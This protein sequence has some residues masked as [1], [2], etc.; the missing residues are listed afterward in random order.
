MKFYNQV[1]WHLHDITK[2][3]PEDIRLLISEKIEL[4]Y[5]GE[6]DNGKI[7]YL[8]KPVKKKNGFTL[9]GLIFE[10]SELGR[11]LMMKTF[12]ASIEHLGIHSI[13][14]DF[15]IYEEWLKGK[16]QKMAAFVINCIEDLC[17]I[18]YMKTRVNDLLKNV[19]IANAVSYATINSTNVRSTQFFLQSALLSFIIAGQ[20]KFAIP[21]KYKKD[22]L[23]I[24]TS[25]YDFEKFLIEKEMEPN[26]SW[27]FDEDVNEKKMQMATTIYDTLMKYGFSKDIVHL[28]YTDTRQLV[29]ESTVLKIEEVMNVLPNTFK[30]Q[31][32]QFS[33][34]PTLTIM[35]SSFKNA[36]NNLMH[37]LVMEYVRKYKVI[38]NYKE[39]SKN[40]QFDDIVY[41][42]QDLAEY[43]R[44]YAQYKR[45]ISKITE[46]IKFMVSDYESD[47]NKDLG[48]I[49]MQAA[50][51]A[52]ATGD[53]N[54]FARDDTPKR[55]EG[56]AI[57]L[58]TSHSLRPF[59]I[60]PRDMALCLA[61]I[62]KE[63]IDWDSWGLYTFDHKFT[64]V[65]DVKEVYGQDV[66]A[67]IGGLKQGGLSFIPD[68][69]E[70]TSRL[71]IRTRAEYN[72]LFVISD[73]LSTGYPDIEEKMI[74]TIKQLHRRGITI[75][76]IGVGTKG[77]KKYS[78][79][80]SYKVDSVYD[81]LSK[82]TKIYSSLI[83]N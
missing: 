83:I 12:M 40:T 76:S 42:E 29:G 74:K 57:L 35:N 55:T 58:D 38:E 72:Y 61:E 63:L 16:E 33:S 10:N 34:D 47:P 19:A 20:Y 5:L 44:T 45:P 28:S 50:I 79:G 2:Y 17:V 21:S 60:N 14:S 41:P 53:S 52:H 54:V 4:P 6:D 1:L 13:I 43:A 78:V 75:I 77:F 59:S 80:Q 81:L 68:A 8:P 71:L 37:D 26:S 82:F 15:S 39:L 73:G 32:L 22:L 66:K 31:G 49:D 30:M 24:I 11:I 65:K 67:R 18:F 36:A 23:S 56:W 7:L 69:L 46:Q 25:L 51:Q 48:I 62:A 27:W 9:N 3:K 70:V 64:I